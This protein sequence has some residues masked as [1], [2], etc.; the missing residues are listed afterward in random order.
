MRTI[1]FVYGSSEDDWAENKVKLE[2]T[3]KS[4]KNLPNVK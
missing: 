3:R 1:F 4:E 2:K